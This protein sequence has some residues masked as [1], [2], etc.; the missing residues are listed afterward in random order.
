MT[1]DEL[2]KADR[3][4]LLAFVCSFAWADL[5][6]EDAERQLVRDLV[7]RL[8]LAPDDAKQVEK[9]LRKPPR[10]EEVDPNTVPLPHRELFLEAARAII[11]A[12]GEV[13]P[14]E[15]AIYALLDQLLR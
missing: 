14:K 13:H 10:P 12:D 3:L 1:L 7:R 15:A 2:S 9:W 4:R 11:V 6:V 5:H 8:K